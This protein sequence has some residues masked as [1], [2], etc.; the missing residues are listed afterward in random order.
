M[1]TVT[2]NFKSQSKE[3][4]KPVVEARNHS[5]A[6][7]PDRKSYS[8]SQQ[9]IKKH[10]KT[11]DHLSSLAAAAHKFQIPMKRIKQLPAQ[12]QSRETS[13]NPDYTL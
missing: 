2:M 8:K 10:C 11:C 4:S 9:K 12:L 13:F 7:V 5:T 1:R 6:R 3:S